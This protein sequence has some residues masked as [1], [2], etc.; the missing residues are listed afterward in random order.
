MGD[1]DFDSGVTSL[2]QQIKKSVPLEDQAGQFED[3][4]Q[5]T[6]QELRAELA[7]LRADLDE[8]QQGKHGRG[9]AKSVEA[10]D[11]TEP[12]VVPSNVPELPAG[13]KETAAVSE[14]RELLLQ[15][16]TNPE[17]RPRVGFFGM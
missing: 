9:A 15:D 14:L 10:F 12:A 13:Y 2:V 4:G 1:D 16:K 8:S 17:F 3:G 11:P 5:I 6:G 7:R